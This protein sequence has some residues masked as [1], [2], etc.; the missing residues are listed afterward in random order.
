MSHYPSLR[1]RFILAVAFSSCTLALNVPIPLTAAS[2]TPRVS[3]SLISLSIEMDRWTD[4]VGTTS[5]NQFFYNTLDN[6]K[7]LTGAPPFIRIGANSEDHT[8]FR[9]DTNVSDLCVIFSA[10]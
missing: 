1:K 2:A 9:Q 5:R 3:P 8:N 10:A 4:W 6:L 7:Q